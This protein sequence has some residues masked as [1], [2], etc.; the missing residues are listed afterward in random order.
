[1]MKYYILSKEV[2]PKV[3][4]VKDGCGQLNLDDRLD[5][6][7]NDWDY[8]IFIKLPKENKD[9]WKVWSKHELYAPK[10]LEGLIFR[11]GAK[12]TDYIGEGLRGFYVNE[13]L[14]TILESVHLP[15]HRFIKTPFIDE[16]TGEIIDEYWR[17]VYDLDSGEHTVDF[18]KS[19]FDFRNYH[20]DYGENF[21]RDISSYNDYL[22]VYRD[23][24]RGLRARKLVFNENFD[25]ELDFLTFTFLTPS[26]YISERLLT[27]MQEAGITGYSVMTLEK[28]KMRSE[29]L[30]DIHTELIFE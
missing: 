4:G 9:W 30:G 28:D 23:T 21:S 3:V 14:K 27:K 7:Y 12:K 1:M 2:E 16:K 24:G 18:K 17:F 22:N 26:L 6:L 5:K 20:I 8:N 13:K 15:N 11:K 25:K 19:E 10:P 29:I